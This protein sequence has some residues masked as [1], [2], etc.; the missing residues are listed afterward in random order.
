MYVRLF[1]LYNG[2]IMSLVNSYFVLNVRN[3]MSCVSDSYLHV[4]W[5]DFY[6]VPTTRQSLR[7]SYTD[8]QLSHSFFFLVNKTSRFFSIML[9]GVENVDLNWLNVDCTY[10]NDAKFMGLII[11]K[12]LIALDVLVN[13][14]EVPL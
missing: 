10:R 6:C 5:S 4:P 7:E 14:L 2:I 12:T 1:M 3:D 13:G 9:N 11:N 8:F